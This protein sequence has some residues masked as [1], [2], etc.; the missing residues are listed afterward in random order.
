MIRMSTRLAE[1]EIAKAPGGEESP[2]GQM[3]PAGYE[4]D[5]V[6]VA[7]VS[8]VQEGVQPLKDAALSIVVE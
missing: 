5:G 4:K 8:I 2:Q 7:P 1:M 6:Q 3:G